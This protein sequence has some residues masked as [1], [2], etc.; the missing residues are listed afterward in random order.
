MVSAG[1]PPCAPLS[2]ALPGQ[3]QPYSPPF[4]SCASF[5]SLFLS[6][7]ICLP[8]SGVSPLCLL[9]VPP[10]LSRKFVRRPL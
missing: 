1:L 10:C 7:Y 5:V 4:A 2:A 8:P 3:C 6:M 9:F